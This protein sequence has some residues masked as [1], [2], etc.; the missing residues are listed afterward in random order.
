MI[1]QHRRKYPI[2]LMCRA[3][4]VS[5][6]GY[7][8]SQEREPSPRAIEN[9]SLVKEIREIH[10]TTRRAYGS[11][12]M[13]TELR[14][15][16][17]N[18]SR[19]RTARLMRENDLQSRRKRRFRRTTESNHSLPCAPNL[20]ERN[21]QADRLNQVWASD[22]TYVWTAERWLYVAVILD[23]HSRKAVGWGMGTSNDANLVLRA[24]RMAIT[25][26]DPAPG[27]IFHSDR[28]S[29]FAS[30]DVVAELRKHGIVQSMSRKGDCWDNAVAESFFASLKSEWLRDEGGEW[31]AAAMADVFSYIEM[32]YNRSRRHS[33][34]GHVSPAEFEASRGI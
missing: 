31:V 30:A 4:G 34:L 13:T 29:T 2:A 33:L 26:R 6:A 32:F 21:F 24:L 28:G 15:R 20:L 7:Y 1:E 23:L 10:R 3:L 17:R 16:G 9:Q 18:C 25:N 11:P 19:H 5:R 8:I 27:L 14:A 22:V 12:R